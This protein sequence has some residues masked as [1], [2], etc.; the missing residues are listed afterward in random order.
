MTIKS[1]F[2]VDV[3]LLLTDILLDLTIKLV[4][5]IISP[6][7]VNTHSTFNGEIHLH[8][9]GRALK[10]TVRPRPFRHFHG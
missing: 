3:K 6:S 7:M 5:K 9:D 10:L 2:S 4:S 1:L 8:T